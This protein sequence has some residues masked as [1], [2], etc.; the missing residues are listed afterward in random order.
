VSIEYLALFA[1]IFLLGYERIGVKELGNSKNGQC[2]DFLLFFTAIFFFIPV[3]F[4][5]EVPEN[6]FRLSVIILIP[7]TIYSLAYIIYVK[8]LALGEISLVGPL[9]NFNVFFLLFISV[10]F[11]NESINLSKISGILLMF[12]GASFLNRNGSILNSIKSIFADKACQL[13]I[14]FSIL[15]AIGRALDRKLVADADPVYYAFILY[16]QMSFFLFLFNYFNGNAKK[17]ILLIKERPYLSII[18]GAINTYAYL[19]L[20]IALKKIEVSIAEPATMFSMVIAMIIAWFI[21]GE[22]IGKRLIG[23]L[24]MI[25]GTY[26]LI[27]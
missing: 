16:I 10:I 8:S 20:L 5:T 22:K 14:M 19:F 23:V 26:L 7:A 21:Y 9:Y 13:M 25:T 15:L 1:R 27:K 18:T 6:L 3:L 12:Y 17:I 4:F 11:L 2:A 24:I